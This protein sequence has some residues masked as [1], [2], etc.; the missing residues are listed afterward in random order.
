M[1]IPEWEEGDDLELFGLKLDFSSLP[2]CP[3]CGG[4]GIFDDHVDTD[5][6]TDTADLYQCEECEQYF[7]VTRMDTK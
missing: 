4:I 1:D 2:I 6:G 7:Y 5:L 3:K